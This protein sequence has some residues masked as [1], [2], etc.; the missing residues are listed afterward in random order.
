MS[1]I[2]LTNNQIL[3]IYSVLKA[4]LP[5]YVQSLNNP[6][7]STK[8][9]FFSV[10]VLDVLEPIV[11]A[12][13][14]SINS[15]NDESFAAYTKQKTDAII[16]YCEKDSNGKPLMKR[17]GYCIKKEHES[18]VKNIIDKINAENKEFLDLLDLEEKEMSEL[19]SQKMDVDLVTIKY[20]SLPEFM[21]PK[22][23][24]SLRP[25]ISD[26]DQEIQAQISK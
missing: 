17:G 1:K 11:K 7:F 22:F 15:K 24:K 19:L 8:F 12:L 23:I 18:A 9:S 2:I 5:S 26:T 13:S 21:L 20:S 10:Y 25:L 3:E 6:K 16:P 4:D 14:T